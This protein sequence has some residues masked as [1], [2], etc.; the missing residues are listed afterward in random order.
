MDSDEEI[1]L[2]NEV[3]ELQSQLRYAGDPVDPKLSDFFLTTL[4]GK[5]PPE[6]ISKW[7]IRVETL[8]Q[9]MERASS[10]RAAVSPAVAHNDLPQNY[11]KRKEPDSQPEPANRSRSTGLKI[12]AENTD[13]SPPMM[14]RNHVEF[15]QMCV[16]ELKQN[17]WLQV[18][19]LCGK[20]NDKYKEANPEKKDNLSSSIFSNRYITMEQLLGMSRGQLPLPVAFRTPRNRNLNKSEA[21]CARSQGADRQR[22]GR[23]PRAQAAGAGDGCKS[24]QG[25]DGELM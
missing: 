8:R 9:R 6:R 13:G 5:S 18:K 22:R 19:E 25:F 4:Q 12:Y 15:I 23:P 20:W 17:P 14:S 10:A 3:D 24:G 1:R 11:P 7:K 16:D 2:I 21:E